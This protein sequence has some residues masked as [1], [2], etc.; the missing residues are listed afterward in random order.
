MTLFQYRHLV[1]WSDETILV[2]GNSMSISPE[3]CSNMYQKDFIS[4]DLS[5]CQDDNR[6][7]NPKLNSFNKNLMQANNLSRKKYFASS[8]KYYLEML[9]DNLLHAY[10]R[11]L[12][13]SLIIK[14][15]Y[16]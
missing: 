5:N 7:G 11:Y 12:G 8:Y 2:L 13:Y 4:V 1:N 9:K 14:T 10:I 15:F 16:K 6:N 3:F